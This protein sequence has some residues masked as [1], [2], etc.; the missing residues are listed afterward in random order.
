MRQTRGG[1]LGFAWGCACSLGGKTGYGFPAVLGRVL[2]WNLGR[3]RVARFFEPPACSPRRGAP[4]G[5][6]RQAEHDSFG[7]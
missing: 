4:R 2:G 5:D 6:G 1:E 7:R 3:E